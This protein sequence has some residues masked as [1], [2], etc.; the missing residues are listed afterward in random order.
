MSQAAPGVDDLDA[1][2][3][4]GS[5]AW[6]PPNTAAP[7]FGD[8]LEGDWLR[9]VHVR[10]DGAL[11]GGDTLP[12]HLADKF[13]GWMK[14]DKPGREIPVLSPLFPP[15]DDDRYALAHASFRPEGPCRAMVVS[16][17]CQ[18]WTCLGMRASTKARDRTLLVPV[19]DVDDAT[20]AK[21]AA[22]RA[23]GRM[24]LPAHDKLSEWPV[25]ELRFVFAVDGRSHRARL[26]DGILH[27][28]HAR[29]LADHWTG[30]AARRGNLVTE[31]NLQKLAT[32]SEGSAQPPSDAALGPLGRLA[33]AF[34]IVRALEEEHLERASNIAEQLDEEATKRGEALGGE[35][36][37][38]RG[39]VLAASLRQEIVAVLR[40][41]SV[42][43][44][45]AIEAV[46]S[47]G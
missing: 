23:L 33:Y 20:H 7:A 10:D 8:V 24:A 2:L 30:F 19:V 22:S 27:L 35:W 28:I 9:D 6:G 16:D 45:D 32:V 1:L 14:Q 36:A 46:V 12:A 40:D 44:D 42:A 43:V 25:A 13:A 21:L 11:L 31:R 3:A 34:D 38:Q 29:P 18:V 39:A 47:L 4:L 41:L 15:S 37:A 26:A 5:G 17:T